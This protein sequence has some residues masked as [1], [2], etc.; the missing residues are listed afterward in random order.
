MN[1]YKTSIKKNHKIKSIHILKIIKENQSRFN[2]K[3]QMDN[4]QSGIH[5]KDIV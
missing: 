1:F 3:V 2:L 4:T 5:L